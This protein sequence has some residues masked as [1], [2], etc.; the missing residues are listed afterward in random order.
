MGKGYGMTL[1]DEFQAPV[2]E[3]LAEIVIPDPDAWEPWEMPDLLGINQWYLEA[4]S[5]QD[6]QVE[7]YNNR[8]EEILHAPDVGV[9]SGQFPT[10]RK[11]VRKRKR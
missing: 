7:K 4:Q 11:R 2:R 8:I 10:P 6:A 5:F 3:R 9:L 1:E